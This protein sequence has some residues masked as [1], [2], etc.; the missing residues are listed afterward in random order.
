MKKFKNRHKINESEDITLSGNIFKEVWQTLNQFGYPSTK[1]VN[2][3]VVID[4]EDITSTD[5]AGSEMSLQTREILFSHRN[6]GRIKVAVTPSR[7][8]RYEIDSDIAEIHYKGGLIIYIT[9]Y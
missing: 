8:I 9:K 4:D 1:K 7:F 6:N 5:F 2:V 3:G